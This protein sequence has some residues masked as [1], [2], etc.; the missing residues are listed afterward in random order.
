M[1]RIENHSAH[2]LPGRIRSS[3]KSKCIHLDPF[4]HAN[5][6]NLLFPDKAPQLSGIMGQKIDFPL[7][8]LRIAISLNNLHLTLIPLIICR[9]F[10][11]P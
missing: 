5:Q 10:Q 8:S 6:H 3:R 2:L 4:I 11:S 7:Q 1:R 9:V